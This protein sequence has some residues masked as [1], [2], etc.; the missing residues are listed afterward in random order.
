MKWNNLLDS[1]CPKCRKRLWFDENESMIMCNFEC[2]FMIEQKRMQEIVAKL[3]SRKLEWDADI[4]GSE[5]KD[6]HS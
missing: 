6:I 2:G 3:V 1:K 4:E 5:E